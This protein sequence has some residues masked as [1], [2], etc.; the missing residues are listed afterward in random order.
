MFETVRDVLMTLVPERDQAGVS[1]HLDLEKLM[2]EIQRGVCDLVKLAEWLAHL[3]KQHCAPIRD[4]LID[5]M[6]EITRRGVAENNC[7]LI[8]RG[9]TELFGILEAMKLVS[10]C[11]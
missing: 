4:C 5:R 11:I 7:D 1:E 8:I 9:L 10:S 2:Q 6:V 3:L